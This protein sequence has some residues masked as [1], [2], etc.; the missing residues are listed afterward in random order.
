MQSKSVFS[1]ISKA[2]KFYDYAFIILVV[3]AISL[4]II[5]LINGNLKTNSILK[6]KETISS[7]C[8]QTIEGEEQVVDTSELKTL[9][10]VSSIADK[11][12][13]FQTRFRKNDIPP[14]TDPQFSSPEEIGDC[15]GQN[16]LVLV[17]KVGEIVKIYPERILQHHLV[18]NDEINNTPVLVSY[19]ALCKSFQVYERTYKDEVLEFGTTGM[20]YKNNDLLF[21]TKTESLWSQYTGKSIVGNYLGASLSPI[22]FS[23]NTYS[24]AKE[25]YPQAKILNFQTGFIKDY[26]DTSYE[27]FAISDEII[28]PQTNISNKFKPKDLVIGL[29]QNDKSYAYPLKDITTTLVFEIDSQTFTIENSASGLLVK[30]GK[31]RINFTYGFWYVWS[32]FYPDTKIIEPK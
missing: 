23:I 30:S 8:L 1:T 19:C 32:D 3:I 24:K 28:A 7:D 21:D 18:V 25:N 4:V 22:P 14:I 20:L 26:R 5:Q 27:E 29:V 6:S 15:L 2:R 17:L 13:I 31:D 10:E 9:S 11:D 12:E 16:E